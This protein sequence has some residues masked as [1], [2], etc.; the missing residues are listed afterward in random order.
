MLRDS[1]V[2]E[3]ECCDEESEDDDREGEEAGV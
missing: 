3:V 1:C 2:L